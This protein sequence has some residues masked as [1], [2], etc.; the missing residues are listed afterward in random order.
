MPPAA[1]APRR[2]LALLALGAVLGLSAAAW[3]LLSAPPGDAMP[4]G[5][6]AV[7]NG[8]PIAA[9]ELERLLAGVASDTE[10][11]VDA[12]MR[13]HVLDRMVEEELLVQRG[14]ELGLASRDR[15]VRADLVE[16]VIRSVVVEAEDREPS[17]DEL[18]AFYE[19]ERALFTRP[20]RLHVRRV[21]VRVGPGGEASARQRAA[22]AARRLRAGEPFEAV[23]RELGDAPVAP[24]PDVPL[25]PTTLRE[26]LGPAALR[27]AQGLAPGAVSD[28]VASG[29]AL[30][31]LW[32]VAR[33][34]A[35]APPLA[36]IEPQVRTEWRRREGDAALR[37][38]LDGLRA[39][40][41]V[42]LA[43]GAP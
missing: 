8:A 4:G 17:A 41:D 33:E 20:E 2:P 23:R 9:S 35:V 13:R 16:A 22:E 21:Q 40:A 34:P 14:L 26:Y 1:P 38:Y 32:L 24:V 6:V 19:A 7:V 3:G 31:V 10:A 36:E 43:P 5:A 29:S 30:H 12:A 42:R 39:R 18:R 37:R 11:P 27:A 25:P 15:R 28:P